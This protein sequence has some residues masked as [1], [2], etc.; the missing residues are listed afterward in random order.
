M[1]KHQQLNARHQEKR[2][3]SHR[4]IVGG[5]LIGLFLCILIARCVYLQ[6]LQHEK[7]STMSD[8]NQLRLVP[9]APSR[10]LIY[11]RKGRLLARNVPAFHLSLIPEKVENIKKTLDELLSLNLID[12]E[13]QERLLEK[14]SHSPSHQRQMIK[15]KLSEEE[16][17]RF[18]VNQF[19][20]PGVTLGVDLIRDY[21]YGPVLAH[22]IGYVS[23]ANR[24]DLSKMDKKRY[25]GTY[26][27]G[28]TGL[29]KHYENTLQGQPGY[30]QIES[31]VLG[32][33]IRSVATY[34]AASGN[35]LHLTL[36]IDLQQIAYEILGD[37]RGAIVALDPKTGGILALASTPS[38]DP[39]TFVRGLN[40]AEYAA[41]R[42]AP[43]RPLFNRPLQGLYPPAST[44]KPL[45]GLAGLITEQ[46]TKDSRIFD[47]GY[48]QLKNSSRQYRDWQK[49]GHGWTDLEK[50]IRE[51]CDIYY[52]TL[53]EKLT[54]QNLS[55]WFSH[56]GFGKKTGID[57]P[58]EQ[59]GLVPDPT[60]KK[61]VHGT[62]WYP[63]ETIITGIGQGYT[64]TT[65]LQLAMMAAYLAN[66]GEAYRPHLNQSI[67]PE[68]LPSLPVNH[69]RYWS[70]I[71]E[72]MHQVVQD[73]RGT[74]YRFF[75]QFPFE[76]AGKTGT[77]QVFGLKQNEKYEHDLVAQHLR[78][79]SLFIGFAPK[80]DPT[81]VVAVVLEHQRASALTGRKILQAYL[82][83]TTYA[84]SNDL[85]SNS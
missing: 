63:G 31:D 73:P 47:P 27:I 82:S 38:Y 22:V 29:E 36:D 2:M 3:T 50:S 66:R 61:R 8:R 67:T 5:V 49:E 33:E 52:Y 26:Q 75:T 15:L 46:V 57:L 68:K 45:L 58:S 25:A 14:I 13:Q 71:I 60:W 51:S 54:I 28:K 62:V 16:V 56:A 30:H 1:Y 20:F 37:N 84:K 76:A 48:F 55:T 21:P 34:P 83:E 79:H 24:D 4:A 17:S 74:A 41:L 53:A 7:Y 11:D 32:R 78:D 70:W 39:N 80:D 23:E 42:D 43:S 40:Q 81:I 77:A 12:L 18:A 64:L 44:V 85:P 65:P 10:G 59:A 6:I 19:R 35:D 69:K 9:I 72:P